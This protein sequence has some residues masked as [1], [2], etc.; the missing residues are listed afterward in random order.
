MTEV[1]V[2]VGHS[3]WQDLQ[4]IGQELERAGIGMLAVVSGAIDLSD[5]ARSLGA[6][7]VLFSPTLP[8]MRP[9]LVQELL[10]DEERP[11]AAVGLIPAAS[12]YAAEYQQ[13]G[14]KGYVTTPLDAVQAQRVPDLVREAVRLAVEERQSR[15]F[16]PVSAEDALAILDRGGWRQQTIA[17]YSPKGGVG[18]T[19]TS[20]NLAS[21]LG[22]KA[23]RPTLL[24]D[25]DMSRANTHVLLDVDIAQEPRNMWALYG[26]VIAQGRRT[27]R[28]VV[29]AQTLQAH[30]LPWRGKLSFLPGI[31]RME[32]AGLEEFTEDT[33]RTLHIFAEILRTA[34]GFFEFRVLDVGPDFNLPIHWAAIQEADTVLLVVTPEKTAI[35]DIKNILPGL[36]G[37]FGTL[38]KFRVVLNGFDEQF[39]IS[40]KEVVK[41][42]D[43]K[44]T[45]VGTLP[46]APA[47]SR[48]AIN[49]GSPMVLEK[50]LAP[51]GEALIKLAA[52]FYP[53]LEALGRKQAR[54]TQSALGKLAR[55]FAS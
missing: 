27:G 53:P 52:N 14:M 10:L 51:I 11:I 38:Q 24:V 43:G 25:A 55:V 54:A 40:P 41:F 18:K 39:G 20:V 37:A 16:T 23:M 15:T 45:V 48:L 2:V 36:E 33:Q 9:A 17:V 42:L 35:M 22:V 47:E 46:Y 29:Q 30:T 28:Y 12:G 7:C 1:S 44:V 49:T 6:D 19:T 32:M 4:M 13:F 34:Q 26:R 3:A 21:A 50:K 31:P 5:Q 8:G